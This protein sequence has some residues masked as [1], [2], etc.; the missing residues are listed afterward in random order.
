MLHQ[1]EEYNLVINSYSWYLNSTSV[2]LFWVTTDQ[3][4]QSKTQE[5]PWNGQHS[6][7]LKELKDHFLIHVNQHFD[8]S[9]SC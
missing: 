8:W 7:L 6:S 3:S 2:V 4:G 9:Q 5:K 1:L